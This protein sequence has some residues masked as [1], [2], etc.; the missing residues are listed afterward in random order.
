MALAGSAARRY[1]EALLEIATE[2]GS[3]NV[4]RDALDRLRAAI[5]PDAIRALRDRHVPIERRRN[6]LDAA[7]TDEP[8]A[9]RAVLVMLLERDRIAIMPEIARAFGDLVDR[10]EGIVHAKISTPVELEPAQRDD[11]VQRLERTSGKR[12]RAT[13]AVDP[14]LLGGARIQLGDRLIDTSVRAQLET[15]Q[16]QLAS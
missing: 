14:A 8:K 2:S 1:A 11:V 7:A 6:A 5:G 15:M 10:R 9:V 3:V 12:I 16:R 4:Y 13:F